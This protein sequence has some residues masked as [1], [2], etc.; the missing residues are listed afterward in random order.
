MGVLSFSCR[1]LSYSLPI[2]IATAAVLL[3][4]FRV[5][6]GLAPVPAGTQ[7]RAELHAR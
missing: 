2:A 5:E 3:W 4:A 6:F 7:P 1:R